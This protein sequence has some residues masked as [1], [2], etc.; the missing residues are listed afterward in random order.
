MPRTAPS[1]R[2]VPGVIYRGRGCILVSSSPLPEP[3]SSLLSLK[4]GRDGPADSL[5]FEYENMHAP[6]PSPHRLG[7]GDLP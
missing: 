3:S 5:T 4:G 2:L 6:Y 1:F 7:Y